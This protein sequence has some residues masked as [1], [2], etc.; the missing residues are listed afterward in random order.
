MTGADVVMISGISILIIV[1]VTALIVVIKTINNRQDK[2]TT[3]N[4]WSG[5][6]S[7]DSQSNNSQIENVRGD[8]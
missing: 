3:Y 1:A 7:T 6:T 2:P 5:D 8:K 4:H